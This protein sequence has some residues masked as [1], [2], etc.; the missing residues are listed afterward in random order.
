MG[1]RARTGSGGK[2]D[3]C[4]RHGTS[5]RPLLLVRRACA[6]TCAGHARAAGRSRWRGP[7]VRGL[8]CALGR[9]SGCRAVRGDDAAHRTHPG[10]R[11]VSYP[12]LLEQLDVA[13]GSTLR[14]ERELGGGGMS[15]VFLAE[16]LDLGRPVVVKVLPPELTTEMSAD[17]FRRE[18]L[19][20]ARLQHPNIVPVLAA[21]QAGAVMYYTMPL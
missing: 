15:R 19:I 4:R 6:A 9:G 5:R 12:S 18:V 14:L 3:R 11:V 1:T 2:V 16:Q 10:Y 8:P 21:G 17:R 7:P 20:A 13:L